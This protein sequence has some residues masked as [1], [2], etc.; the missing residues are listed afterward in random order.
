M[1]PSTLQQSSHHRPL[2]TNQKYHNKV[3]LTDEKGEKKRKKEKENKTERVRKERKRERQ[4]LQKVTLQ[5]FIS[6][7]VN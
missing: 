5:C 2:P 6:D 7:R 3:I 4:N 1:Y